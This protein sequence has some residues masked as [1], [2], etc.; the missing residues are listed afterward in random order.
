MASGS[1][2]KA[3]S[4]QSRGDASAPGAGNGRR[5]IRTPSGYGSTL[6][7]TAILTDPEPDAGVSKWT[8]RSALTGPKILISGGMS[9]R[10]PLRAR[11]NQRTKIR[12]RDEPSAIDTNPKLTIFSGTC[13]WFP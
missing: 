11:G 10:R 4:F 7:T 8:W 2:S 5:S 1:P 3:A 9:A 13:W 12:S 6:L